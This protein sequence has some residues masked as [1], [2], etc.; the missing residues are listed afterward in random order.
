[1]A[2]SDVSYQWLTTTEYLSMPMMVVA[3]LKFIDVLLPAAWL[4]LALES[5][6]GHGGT[7]KVESAPDQGS[8]FT[9]SFKRPQ[10]S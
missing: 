1:M 6:N 7:I 3:A 2:G 9:A 4:A 8:I 5:C 10:V